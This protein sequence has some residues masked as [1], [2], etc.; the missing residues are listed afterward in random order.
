ML[1]NGEVKS[2]QII[3]HMPLGR[4]QILIHRNRMLSKGPY[5]REQSLKLGVTH[6]VDPLYKFLG[7]IHDNL[8]NGLIWAS[9]D[10]APSL[11]LCKGTDL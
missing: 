2:I 4:A 5:A 10:I 3:A 1:L 7:D 6:R 11:F 8:V 9:Y